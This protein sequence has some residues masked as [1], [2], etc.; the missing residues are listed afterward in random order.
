MTWNFFVNLQ[1][2]QGKSCRLDF[3]M[4]TSVAFPADAAFFARSNLA[5]GV[6]DVREPYISV[7]NVFPCPGSPARKIWLQDAAETFQNA[8]Q[9]ILYLKKNNKPIQ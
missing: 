2:T 8:Y 7:K 4:P 9:L 1:R 3:L 5:D 6:P